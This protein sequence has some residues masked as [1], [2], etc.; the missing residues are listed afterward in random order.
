MLE[1]VPGRDAPGTKFTSG[2]VLVAGGSRGLTG[3]PCLA[4]EAAMRAGAGY[5]TA[6]VPASLETI[7]EMRLLEVMT[8]GLPDAGG[9]LTR[10]G[11]EAVLGATQRGG[12]LVLGPGVGR[13]D[14]ALAFVRDVAARATVALRARRRRPERA[15]RAARAPRR[16]PGADRADPARGRAGPPAGPLES[17]E[18]GA[19]RLACA[20]EAAERAQAIVVLKGD[21]TIVAAPGGVVA[22]NALARRPW[23]PRAPATCSAASSP[24]CWPRA[25]SRSRPP[26]P[27]CAFT[28]PRAGCAAARHG[29]DG[30]IASDVI[31]ALPR[32]LDGEVDQ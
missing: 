3:A 24:R 21:D 6:C 17:E 28:R 11:I 7:F 18:V 22:V 29:A 4:A 16:P 15:R 31:E 26:A 25:W 12:A 27:G 8:R 10:K 13:A 9:A 23:P 14:G 1:L 19:Q 30:V 2:H 20:R 5:V 32:A